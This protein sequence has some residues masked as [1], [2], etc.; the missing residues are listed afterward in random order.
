MPGSYPRVKSSDSRVNFSNIGGQFFQLAEPVRKSSDS[1]KKKVLPR[2]DVGHDTGAQSDSSRTPSPKES[3]PS[4]PE[5]KKAKER[6]E[7]RARI[8]KELGFIRNLEKIDPKLSPAMA[9]EINNAL[10]STASRSVPVSV[11]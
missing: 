11:Y 10:N 6:A 7:E 4:T 9:S 1:D 2:L 5:S 3:K 8:L